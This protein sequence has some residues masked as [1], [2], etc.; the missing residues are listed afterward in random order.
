MEIDQAFWIEAKK[1][2]LLT[3]K[4]VGG[5]VN[6]DDKITLS[7]GMKAMVKEFDNGVISGLQVNGGSPLVVGNMV[8]RCGDGS[9]AVFVTSADD[10]YDEA[11][12]AHTLLFKADG[13]DVK[14]TSPSG[15]VKL[16]CTPSGWYSCQL[17]SNE[18]L[19]I[20]VS[21]K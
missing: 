7:N 17:A 13:K 12:K 11:P 4:I 21:P 9:R 3:G 6:L 5:F 1:G 18:A 2:Y 15:E 16:N 10:P 19:L 14:A 20:E 8:S